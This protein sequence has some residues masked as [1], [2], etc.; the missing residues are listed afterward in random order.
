MRHILS[1]ALFAC[2]LAPLSAQNTVGTMVYESDQTFDGYNMVIPLFGKDVMLVDMCGEVVHSWESADTIRCATWSYL[3]DNGDLVMTLREA[4]VAGDVIWTGGGGEIIERRTWNNELLWSYHLN[5]SLRRLHHDIHVLDNGNVLAL[6]WELKDSLEYVEAGGDISLIDDVL[7]SEAIYELQP[8]ASGGA[9][10][11]WEWH[12]WDHLVQDFDPTKANY[13]VVADHPEKINLNYHVGDPQLPVADWLHLNSIHYN[14]VFG[15]IIVSVPT[16][17]EAWI[18]DHAGNNSGTLMWR[19][20][21]PQAYDRGTADDQLLH[22]QHDVR[23]AYEGLQLSDPNYG[24]VTVF[25]NRVPDSTGMHSE[26][27]IIEPVYDLYEN[28]YVMDPVTNTY[29]PSNF[30]DVYAAPTPSDLFSPITSNYQILPGGH[31]LICEGN[32]GDAI[33]LNENQEVVWRYRVPLSSTG[34]NLPQPVAQGTMLAPMQNLVFRMERFGLNHPAFEGQNLS[35]QGVIE[36]NPSPLA[37]CAMMEGC[38]DP[39]ACNYDSTATGPSVNCNYNNPSFEATSMFVLG[40]LNLELG[41]NGGYAVSESLPVMLVET[42]NGM[43]WEFD[44]VTEQI[45][46]DNGYELL[47][48]DLT[49]QLV[50]LC[51][52]S[53]N[54]LDGMGNAYSLAYDGTGYINELYGGYIAPASNFEEGCGFEF[55]CNYDPCALYNFDLCEFL[56]VEVTVTSD[57]GSGD[58]MASASASGGVEPYTYGWYEADG[59][60]A[61]AFGTEVDGLVAGDYYVIAV[62]STGCIGDVDFVIET[63]DGLLESRDMLTLFPNPASDLLT[64]QWT[65][66]KQGVIRVVDMSGQEVITQE[67]RGLQS[68]VNLSDLPQGTYLLQ[69]VHPQGVQTERIQII[70]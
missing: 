69:L 27:S 32:Q 17:S 31:S 42:D 68:I 26:A 28:L 20:G 18:I 8:N 22:F 70:R 9:D 36:L 23:W 45:L 13:G 4:N 10:V 62:D 37:S 40:E 29:L 66:R 41:C 63:V 39:L 16:F 34:V 49:N 35:P 15:Q 57:S 60:D 59:D 19:W 51:G 2:F 65:S 12:A 46:I 48:M 14:P 24:K 43:T 6:V 25:N 53:L 5:D 30:D 67:H 56:D 3:Q 47:V 21:N 61:F 55:A 33:E 54:V 38:T 44:P 11:V 7:W 58:G 1:L 64:I 52:D 50:S